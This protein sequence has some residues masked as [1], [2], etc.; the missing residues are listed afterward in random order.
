MIS[1]CSVEP[2]VERQTVICW[3]GNYA[4]EVVSQNLLG[5]TNLLLVS[6]VLS[7]KLDKAQKKNQ[8][9]PN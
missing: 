5:M 2:P 1:F 4:A 6:H 8:T 9:Y 3:V 7:G